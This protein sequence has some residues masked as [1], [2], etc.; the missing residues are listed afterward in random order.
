MLTNRKT[1]SNEARQQQQQ[2]QEANQSGHDPQQ[3]RRQQQYYMADELT[4]PTR[5]TI[6]L[7]GA[8][9]LFSLFF[10]LEFIVAKLVSSLTVGAD[11]AGRPGSFTSATAGTAE[12]AASGLCQPPSWGP[13]CRSRAERPFQWLR[14]GAPPPA[15]PT[16]NE[17]TETGDNEISEKSA[18]SAGVNRNSSSGGKE[19]QSLRRK[20]RTTSKLGVNFELI[21]ESELALNEAQTHYRVDDPEAVGPEPAPEDLLVRPELKLRQLLTAYQVAMPFDPDIWTLSEPE[22]QA[23]ELLSGHLFRCDAQLGSLVDS[24]ERALAN[25][26]SGGLDSAE[27]ALSRV[28]YTH[29]KLMKLLDAVGR[30]EA[31]LLMGHPFWLGSY[32]ECQHLNALGLG[33]HGAHGRGRRLAGHTDFGTRYC[34][35]K[36]AFKSWLPDEEGRHEGGQPLRQQSIKVG[37]CLPRQCDSLELFR[38]SGGGAHREAAIESVRRL[39]ERLVRFNLNDRIYAGAHFKLVDIYCLPLAER[40]QLGAF[41]YLLLSFIV[42]W[43]SLAILCTA[44]RAARKNRQN[45]PPND[46]DG[47]ADIHRR[48]AVAQLEELLGE[49]LIDKLAIDVNFGLFLK[50]KQRS[51]FSQAINDDS[52]LAAAPIVDLNVLDSVKHLG[53]VGVIFAHVLLTYLTLG[54]SYSHTIENIGRDF[55]TM[56]LLSLNNI[57]D[58]FFVIS[59]LLVAYLALKRTHSP[60]TEDDVSEPSRQLPKVSGGRDGAARWRRLATGYLRTVANRYLRMAPLYFLVYAFAKTVSVNLGEGPLWDYATNAQSLRGLCKRESWLWPL[61]FASDLKPISQHCV[62]PA[63][64]ISVD[65][66]FFLLAPVLVQALRLGGAGDGL[67]HAKHRRR[68][69]TASYALFGSLI[70]ASAALTLADYQSLLDYV[71]M[72]DFAKLRLH[73]FTVLIRHAAHAY[74]R[75]QNRMGPILIGLIGGHLLFEYEERMAKRAAVTSDGQRRRSQEA[76]A[77]GWPNWMRGRYFKLILAACAAFVLAPCLV[78]V[79]ERARRWQ[80]TMA[81]AAADEQQLKTT[82]PAAARLAVML[83]ALG[84]SAKFDYYLALAGFVLI[85]LLWSVCNCVVFLRLITDLNQSAWARFMSLGLWQILSKL[86][87]AILLVHFEVI[88]Y[89]AMSRLAHDHSVTWCQLMGKFSFAYL[90]SM[91][92]ACPLYVLFEQPVHRLVTDWRRPSV[93]PAAG[94][95]RD[96]TPPGRRQREHDEEAPR[97]NNNL[98]HGHDNSSSSMQQAGRQRHSNLA[99]HN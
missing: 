69:R 45:H 58:T 39:A 94:D 65:M 11:G 96:A 81:A 18:D 34:V 31:G 12:L 50:A 23:R 53:C 67:E 7:I 3:Q 89:E 57:V 74:S 48:R 87:Y 5:I 61:T 49:K 15:T 24:I 68:R 82:P 75:P 8:S 40:R 79:R 27:P 37:L 83:L 90:G 42:G 43:L 20:G 52:S 46:G 99:H 29:Y 38:H 88:A 13:T 47:G 66:Q 41:A 71:S 92:F 56:L 17:S 22:Q 86:N 78:Q 72:R 97:P 25:N 80:A 30:P 2:P 28:G 84:T 73:V 98:R 95:S 19:N 33:E 62:P 21:Y 14:V 51:M 6:I 1:R 63:W 4:W 91:L 60:R 32:V 77:C 76:D 55:R 64:S 44:L 16:R 9:I 54:T 85:K 70:V 26:G 59:G 93:E 36:L 35:G 10:G